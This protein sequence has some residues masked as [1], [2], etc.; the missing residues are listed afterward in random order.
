MCGAQTC[1]ILR[2]SDNSSTK[3]SVMRVEAVRFSASRRRELNM[4]SAAQEYE[5]FIEHKLY[6]LILAAP[7]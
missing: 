7:N 5:C 1:Q 2:K 6:T 4:P 3:S